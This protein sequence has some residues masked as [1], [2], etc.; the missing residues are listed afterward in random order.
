MTKLQ[1]TLLEN[2]GLLHIFGA[3]AT[4][5]LQGMISNDIDLVTPEKSVYAALLTPQGKFL[6]D[7]FVLRDQAG[8][9]Y[10]LDCD[11]ARLPD[12]Q[13]RLSMYKMR[14][15]VTLEDAS[16]DL[17]LVACYGDDHSGLT[18][19]GDDTAGSTSAYGS[20]ILFVDPRLAGLGVR[21]VLPRSDMEASLSAAGFVK[22]SLED[23]EAHR[24]SLGVPEAGRDVLI[25][26]S[27]PL[28]CNF[29]E[30]NAVSYTKGCYVGQE[31]TARTHHRAT[32]KKRLLPVKIT[33]H[34]PVAGTPIIHNEREVGEMRSG[35]GGQ[36]IAL[37]R[38]E[39]LSST[40][41]ASQPDD[42]FEIDGTT[43]QPWIPDWV[44]IKPLTEE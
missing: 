40:D 10:L 8:T 39:Y 2:R 16:A 4:E 17:A 21:I 27:F 38:L 29:D 34:M 1:Y 23:Q 42:V 15:D 33:G 6:F 5:F 35:Q 14:A 18:N 25:E 43:I 28:E 41:A 9:G 12:L 30:M 20:G 36:G 22:A 26:K 3:D 31:M 44:D 19:G 32:L 24:L 7:F 13:K 37:I 11:G